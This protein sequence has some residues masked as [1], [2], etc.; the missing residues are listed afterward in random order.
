MNYPS[1]DRTFLGTSLVL[2][3]LAVATPP[4]L[5]HGSK[6]PTQKQ[7]D[8]S[9][10]EQKAFGIAGDPHKVT[11][12]IK[13]A[14]SDKMR[15]SPNSITVKQG[16]TVKFVVSNSGKMLHEMVIGT[17]DELKEHGEMM[18]KFPELE[19]E[20]PFMTHVVPGASE[21]LVWNFNRPGDFRFACLIPGHFDAG[22][23]GK[24]RVVARQ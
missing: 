9:S 2:F 8:P 5:A 11:R 3:S 22:M 24:I 23:L 7:F 16:E 10:A 15:F 14:M 12:T 4:A 17:M 20:E 18:K 6:H 19:H 21:A 13:I 1:F